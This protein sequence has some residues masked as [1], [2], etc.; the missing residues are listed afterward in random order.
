M[1]TKC[2]ELEIVRDIAEGAKHRRLNRT[3]PPVRTTRTNTPR[4]EITLT[5]GTVLSMSDVFDT[6]ASHWGKELLA[7]AAPG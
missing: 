3:N 2:G 5:D 6:V 7:A 4:L 1:F